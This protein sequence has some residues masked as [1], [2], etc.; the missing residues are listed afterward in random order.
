M[1][2]PLKVL[3]TVVD[4]ILPELKQVNNS[5]EI[6]EDFDFDR[7]LFPVLRDFTAFL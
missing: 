5:D 4:E 3:R 2:H 1:T 6:D 7:E